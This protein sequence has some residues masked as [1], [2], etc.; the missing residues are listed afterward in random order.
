MNSSL[1]DQINNI[2]ERLRYIRDRVDLMRAEPLELR[3]ELFK[4]P[5]ETFNVLFS[6]FLETRSGAKLF[7]L[8][9]EEGAGLV[10]EPMTVLEK[11]LQKDALT[12]SEDETVRVLSK[13]MQLLTHQKDI[14]ETEF[15]IMTPGK[16]R[17]FEIL[18]ENGTEEIWFYFSET[19][20]DKY[21]FYLSPEI[22]VARRL[23][24]GKKEVDLTKDD[25]DEDPEDRIEY[26]TFEL[27]VT[28]SDIKIIEFYL[29]IL[30]PWALKILERG[31][32]GET[33]KQNQ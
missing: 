31:S 29:N 19:R 11:K 20:D 24:T 21:C 14:N 23:P 15:T 13:A 9:M 5:N 28:N 17:T 6:D 2:T 26:T 25:E 27:P 3:C 12:H 1:L 32:S 30:E 18:T 8:A 33:W 7:Q 22:K 16:G 10:T 4:N